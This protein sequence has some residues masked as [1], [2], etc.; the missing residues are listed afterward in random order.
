MDQPLVNAL[1]SEKEHFTKLH[2]ALKR[3]T[4]IDKN[5]TVNAVEIEKEIQHLLETV[6]PQLQQVWDNL[7]IRTKHRLQRGGDDYNKNNFDWMAS[8]LIKDRINV[9]HMDTG[10]PLKAVA[11]LK[12]EDFVPTEVEKDYVFQSLV[13]Y[14]SHRIVERYPLAFKSIKSSIKPN[15]SHQFQPEMDAKS[16]EFTGDLFTKSESNTEDLI[17]MMSEI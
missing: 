5:D 12:I 15:K 7:N 6:P 17:G 16:E 3:R 13:H 8:I 11:D 10:E 14:Y 1:Q 9:N 2:N 4:E